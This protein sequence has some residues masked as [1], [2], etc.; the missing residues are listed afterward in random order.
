[1]ARVDEFRIDD[2]VRVNDQCTWNW[3]RGATGRVV[4]VDEPN[5]TVHVILDDEPNDCA[6]FFPESLDIVD[7]KP[8]RTPEAIGSELAAHARLLETIAR[9]MTN[10]EYADPG[11]DHFHPETAE[12]IVKVLVNVEALIGQCRRHIEKHKMAGS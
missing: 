8:M 10:G 11:D 3:W 4:D 9:R 12:H 1:M 5:R 6:G 2:R 7:G